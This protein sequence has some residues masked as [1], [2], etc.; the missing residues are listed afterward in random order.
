MDH[1]TITCALGLG[2]AL[3]VPAAS[4]TSR[5]HLPTTFL[6]HL[7]RRN[8]FTAVGHTITAVIGAGVLSLPYAISMLGWVAGP[9]CL[10]LFASITLYTSQLLADCGVIN[11]LRQRTYTNVVETTFGRWG[12]LTIGW[13]VSR[14]WLLLT[15]RGLQAL[16]GSQPHADL[17][18]TSPHL[19]ASLLSGC[20][21]P[22]WCSR[23]WPTR[24]PADSRCSAWG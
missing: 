6:P 5:Q 13:C 23:R 12:Y 22:T 17:T 19:C 15:C 7:P 2:K 9:L 20:S 16:G 21:T 24:S 8:T 4:G 14:P 10:G 18:L 11:G 3:A 1:P